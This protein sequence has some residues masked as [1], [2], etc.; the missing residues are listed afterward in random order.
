MACIQSVTIE[1]YNRVLNAH[2]I[3][4]VAYSSDA[5][6]EWMSCKNVLYLVCAYQISVHFQKP[7]YC[8]D[9]IHNAFT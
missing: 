1:L 3:K 8:T 4:C 7:M 6:S 9:C 5:V 2:V